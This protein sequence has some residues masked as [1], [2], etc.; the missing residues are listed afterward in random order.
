MSSAECDDGSFVPL[1]F[2][3]VAVWMLYLNGI[4]SIDVFS[5]SCTRIPG[6]G[7]NECE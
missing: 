6:M 4:I 3:L 5:F 2:D 1:G 7:M